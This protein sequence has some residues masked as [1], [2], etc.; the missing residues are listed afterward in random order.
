MTVTTNNFF[1]SKSEDEKKKNVN[2]SLIYIINRNQ[3][4][5]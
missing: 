5:N 3:K 1:K 4:L 2:D